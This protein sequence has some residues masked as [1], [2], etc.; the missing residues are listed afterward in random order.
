MEC[1]DEEWCQT[2]IFLKFITDFDLQYINFTYIIIVG[3]V[4]LCLYQL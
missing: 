2:N 1:K 4:N 3:L